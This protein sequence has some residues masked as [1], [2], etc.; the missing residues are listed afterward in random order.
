MKKS[1]FNV[2]EKYYEHQ[3]QPSS[4][5]SGAKIL[6]DV[7]IYADNIISARRPDIVLIDKQTKKTI[8][9]SY[10]HLTLPTIYSV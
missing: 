3:P 5:K 7:N 4:E 6:W 10:T 2:P 9:V 1:G 8:T